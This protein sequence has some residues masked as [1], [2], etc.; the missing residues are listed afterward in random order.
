MG[1][2]L[3]FL[4]VGDD[5]SGDAITL[6]FGNLF[7]DR[8]QQTVVVIDGGFK[9]SG[10]DVVSH[11]K[12]HY[13]T[14]RVD[15]VVSTHPDA[16]HVGGVETI[17][18]Q[19][20]VGC[21]WMH[22]PWNHTDDIA[23]MFKDGRV[24]DNSVTEALRKSL[25]NARALERLAQSKEI[26]IIEPFAGIVDNSGKII[27]LGPTTSFY[28]NLLPGFRG[29]PGPVAPPGILQKA[30]SGVVEAVKWVAESWGIETLGDDGETS[31]EN[32]SSVILL[33]CTD[34]HYLLLTSDAGIPALMDV[35]NRLHGIGF[36]FS[37]I[38]F[39]QVPHH[40]SRR[41]V[42]PTVLN[43]LLGPKLAEEKTLRTA[44]VSAAENGTPKHPSKKVMNAF[45]RRGAPV[46]CTGGVGR[47]HFN[48]APARIGWSP[49]V[50]LPFYGQVEE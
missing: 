8:N 37:K 24:T 46:H 41:N 21:L 49:S 33:V 1:Y 19:C 29:T 43:H 12:T 7:G 18:D 13:G 32:N 27:V 45:R 36:D 5:K 39:V 23:K 10:T 20:E 40:G 34:D 44:Y 17:L 42:G 26:P 16:D 6:R 30:V 9:E 14:N 38:T 47:C 48:N 15:L 11:L 2:E 3:D 31:A 28:E 35:V 25:D 50:P 4:P 22:Q